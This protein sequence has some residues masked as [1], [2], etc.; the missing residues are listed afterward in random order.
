MQH[1][2]YLDAFGVQTNLSPADSFVGT[3]AAIAAV[4]LNVSETLRNVEWMIV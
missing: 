2:A 4:E 3:S 1:V